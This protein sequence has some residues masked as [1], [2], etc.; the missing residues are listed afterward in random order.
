MKKRLVLPTR[1]H[2]GKNWQTKRIIVDYNQLQWIF[3]AKTLKMILTVAKN[4][5]TI[6]SNR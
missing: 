5:L 4:G 1:N 6:D 2:F 3:C